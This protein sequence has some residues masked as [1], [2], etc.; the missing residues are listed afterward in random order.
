MIKLV[1]MK[2]R[3]SVLLSAWAGAK[4]EKKISP[5]NM[6]QVLKKKAEAR[7]RQLAGF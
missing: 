5:G 2:E 7:G 3:R 4:I 1:L 6:D